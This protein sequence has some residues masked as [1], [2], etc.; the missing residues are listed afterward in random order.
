MV[1][2]HGLTVAQLIKKEPP[3]VLQS[4][5]WFQKYAVTQAQHDEWYEEAI[6]LLKKRTRFSKKFI[7]RSFAFDYVNCAPDIIN[8]S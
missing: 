3:E 8:E 7:K 1:K 6:D 2:C 5:E 4:P